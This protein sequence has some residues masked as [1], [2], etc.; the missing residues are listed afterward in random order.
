MITEADLSWFA[1]V[2]DLRA[3]AIQ[4]K[5]KEGRKAKF[6]LIVQVYDH[7]IMDRLRSLTGLAPGKPRV[8]EPKE[9][10][11]RSCTEHCSQSHVSHSLRPQYQW[12]LRGI[13]AAIVMYNVL[14][15]MAHDDLGFAGIIGSI[16]LNTPLK[17]NTANAPRA[18][19]KRLSQAGWEIPAEILDAVI[20]TG[21]AA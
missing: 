20:P 4:T 17:G 12:Q 15:Y 7:R 1:G 21:D 16:F 13:S 11:Q 3:M 14:P 8:R 5:A 18:A 19:I 2:L 10:M 6:E 9:W